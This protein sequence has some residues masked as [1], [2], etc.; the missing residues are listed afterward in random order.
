[1]ADTSPGASAPPISQFW[2]LLLLWVSGASLRVTILATPPVIPL[3][4]DDL[5]L[6]QKA[7]GALNGL[8]VL[9]FAFGALSGSLL[10]ARIGAIRALVVGLLLT[11]AAGALRGLG[12]DV[13][14]LFG[15][16]IVM[17]LGIA[18]MQPAMPTL[19][20]RWMPDHAGRATA[21]YVN[22]LLVGEIIGA[23]LTLPVALPLTGS[24]GGALA[25]WS[26]IPVLN[27]ALVVYALSRGHV[28]RPGLRGTVAP[29]RWLP[30]WR[31][32]AM[33]KCGIVLGCASSMYFATNSFLPDFLHDSGR[34][35]LIGP[36]LSALNAGQLPASFLLLFIADRAVGRAWP[37]VATG[38]LCAC[39][40]AGLVLAETDGLVILFSAIV[41]F[42]AAANLIL[43][44]ALPPLLAEHDDVHRF[45]A[46]V[47]LIGY[48][49]SF[50]TPVISGATWD[51]TGFP[52]SAFLPIGAAAI[53]LALMATRLATPHDGARK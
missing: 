21:V 7:I 3:I 45:S 32:G 2:A 30:D 39:A 38:L 42:C 46:G 24:W 5:Q 8:P 20:G 29:S 10:L 50:V 23:A 41:G 27:I 33:V 11:G 44:L 35:A 16:T 36:A 47:F 14:V 19:V 49:L 12:P 4:H 18:I 22:G 6:S 15:M 48:F 43:V 17:G 31:N 26:L 28:R 40:L 37:L 53:V 13:A 1:M 34:N 52:A 25:V 51:A 9:M